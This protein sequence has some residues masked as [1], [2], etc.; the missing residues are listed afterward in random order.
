MVIIHPKINY[1]NV[2]LV[3]KLNGQDFLYDRA[4][5][6]ASYVRLWTKGIHDLARPGDESC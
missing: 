4:K 3:R 6:C 5:I 2:F 1:L